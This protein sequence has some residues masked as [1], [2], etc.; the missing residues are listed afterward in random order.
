MSEFKVIGFWMPEFMS[1]QVAQQFY[2][3]VQKNQNRTDFVVTG[4]KP[5]GETVKSGGFNADFVYDVKLFNKHL[6]TVFEYR[7]KMY[8]ARGGFANTGPGDELIRDTDCCDEKLYSYTI[9]I[10][11][12]YYYDTDIIDVAFGSDN[13]HKYKGIGNMV[14]KR[15]RKDEEQRIALLKKETNKN[16]LDFLN[17]FTGKR[18]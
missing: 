2:E 13:I 18:L 15:W 4:S 11:E 3:L 9:E 1:K 14:A 8:G 6:C 5:K 7:P 12:K 16:S 10:E 17:S